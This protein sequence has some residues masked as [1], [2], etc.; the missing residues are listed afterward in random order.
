MLK[1]LA[2]LPIAPPTVLAV[3]STISS[4]ARSNCRVAAVWLLGGEVWAGWRVAN[5]VIGGTDVIG[6]AVAVFVLNVSAMALSIPKAKPIFSMNRMM[7]ARTMA[8]VIFKTPLKK[9]LFPLSL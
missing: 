2:V 1:A 6:G 9:E 3:L 7:A 8:K 4:A 5:L